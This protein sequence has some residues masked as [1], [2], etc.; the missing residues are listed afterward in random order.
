[1]W[2]S[3][4]IYFWPWSNPDLTDHGQ[5]AEEGIRIPSAM[6]EWQFLVSAAA[7]N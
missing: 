7:L 6:A 2:G 3:E 5:A 1:M 4:N